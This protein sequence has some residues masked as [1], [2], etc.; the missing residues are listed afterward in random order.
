M[1]GTLPNKIDLRTTVPKYLKTDRVGTELI[2]SDI[3]QL[4]SIR[5]YLGF[6]GPQNSLPYAYLS[7][8][9]KSELFV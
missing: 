4:K 7:T 2:Y 5:L 3:S 6:L 1:A 9:S 8:F